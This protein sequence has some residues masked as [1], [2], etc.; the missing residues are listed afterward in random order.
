MAVSLVVNI[1]VCL[2]CRFVL[3]SRKFLSRPFGKGK[4]LCLG[5]KGRYQV[6]DDIDI[7]LTRKK[8]Y[9]SS[10]EIKGLRALLIYS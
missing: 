7:L 8:G 4:R 1:S 3:L 2:N 6:K 9:P 10:E 5:I